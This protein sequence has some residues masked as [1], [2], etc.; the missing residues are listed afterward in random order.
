MHTN[1]T[2]C[3]STH[4]N[5]KSVASQ[6][7]MPLIVVVFL[8]LTFGAYELI[9]LSTGINEMGTLMLMVPGS[10]VLFPVIY[11]ATFVIVKAVTVTSAFV[12]TCH[13]CGLSWYEKGANPPKRAAPNQSR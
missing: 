5:R 12:A 3:K 8:A 1:C 10:L 4:I 11:Y 9:H 2:R 6:I 7:T 13:N